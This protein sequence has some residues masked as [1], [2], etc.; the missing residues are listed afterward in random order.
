ML[1]VMNLIWKLLKQHVSIS[2]LGVFFV[3]N[4]IGLTIIL[5]GV[6]LYSDIK[7]L[8]IGETSLIGSDY[9]IITRPVER[10]G[11]EPLRF[12]REDIEEL[13]EQA[14]I[15]DVGAFVSSEYEVYGGVVFSGQ[16]LS[17]MMFFE[18]V[19]D[20]FVD[21]ES[22]DWGF[23]SVD[24]V[25]PIII[26]RNY[27]NLYNFGFSNTQGLPQITEDM[28]KRIELD[29]ELSGNGLD[30][31]FRGSVVGFSD[32]L[33][34]ILVPM[35]FMNWANERYADGSNAESSRL[36]LE[37]DD[38]ASP[39]LTSYL[40]ANGYVAEDKPAESSKAMSLLKVSIAII[41]V[42]GFVFSILSI[43]ILTLS[44]YL[45]LQKNVDKLENLVLIGYSPQAVAQPYVRLTI[46]LNATIAS[47]GVTLAL[48][49]QQLY[50]GHL[51]V[52]T[53]RDL[54][55]SPI[56]AIVAG[57]VVASATVLFNV[58]IIRRKIGQISRKR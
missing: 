8:L 2:E 57:I 24:K 29:I 6:Q 54:P 53:G 48:V 55:C 14:F 45:L 19:P 37:V 5:C 43:I 36:I 15:S 39:E 16:R 38:P 49:A 33:N 27:L 11:Q 32:R 7:P 23:E 1:E 28:I 56:A 3:A 42:I 18:S 47:L 20:A 35:S 58:Y 22:R 12:S 21:V 4:L 40:E 46:L 10:F 13:C 44:I 9:M 50:M 51:S 31:H 30:E 52:L 34:T 17:T 41:V 26:P 25:I